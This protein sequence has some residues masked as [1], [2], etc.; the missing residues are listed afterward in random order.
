MYQL[1][2]IP[3]HIKQT[4]RTH[5]TV[6][7]TISYMNGWLSSCVKALSKKFSHIEQM[8]GVACEQWTGLHLKRILPEVGFKPDLC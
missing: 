1:N 4:M 7:C 5:N 3:Q 8:K 2:K 6:E